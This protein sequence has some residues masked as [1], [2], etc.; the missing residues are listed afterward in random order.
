MTE[1][2]KRGVK[3][4]RRKRLSLKC[5]APLVFEGVGRRRGGAKMAVK[6]VRLAHRG[7]VRSLQCVEMSLD[8][9]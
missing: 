9:P 4:E 1:S 8:D 6:T 3:T 5:C 2:A 7:V